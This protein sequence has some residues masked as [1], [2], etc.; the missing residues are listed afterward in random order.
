MSFLSFLGR[1]LIATALISSAYLHYSHP[2]NS[3]KEFVDNYNVI[4]ALSSKHLDFDIP[5]DNVGIIL[6]RRTGRKLSEFLEG[7][8]H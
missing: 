3:I 8:R 6:Y 4:D 5:Y 7:L 1:L 2:S